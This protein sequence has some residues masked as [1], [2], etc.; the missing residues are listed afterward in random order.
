[1]LKRRTSLDPCGKEE[2]V[3]HSRVGS[4]F[5][6]P[7]R[8]QDLAYKPITS[9]IPFLIKQSRET[10]PLRK[11]RRDQQQ[12]CSKTRAFL[13]LDGDEAFNYMGRGNS[14]DLLYK[15][16]RWMLPWHNS[17]SWAHFTC[18]FILMIEIKWDLFKLNGVILGMYIITSFASDEIIILFGL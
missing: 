18:R 1:M 11:S 17:P 15:E 4:R 9:P 16:Q 3:H 7:V 13:V 8:V 6:S 12:D 14:K 2:I 5:S 10:P